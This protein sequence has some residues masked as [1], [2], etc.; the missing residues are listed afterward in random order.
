MAT[1]HFEV[2]ESALAAVRCGPEEFSAELRL[3]AAVAWL[4][5]GKI[6]DAVAAEIAGLSL[7]DFLSAMARMKQQPVQGDLGKA[8]GEANPDAAKQ[9]AA[10]N[11]FFGI[12]NLTEDP[13]EYQDRIRGEWD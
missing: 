9:T 2:P 13:L 3:A 5:Q 1:V 4:G 7:P 8:E 10:P 6:E 12:L 11:Q